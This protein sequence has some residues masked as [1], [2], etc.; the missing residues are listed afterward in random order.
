MSPAWY[1]AFQ[2]S[3]CRIMPKSIYTFR[4][5]GQTPSR[6]FPMRKQ[7]AAPHPHSAI[8]QHVIHAS[9]VKIL[10]TREQRRDPCLSCLRAVWRVACSQATYG[11]NSRD[12]Q[13]SPSLSP[14]AEVPDL[15]VLGFQ[16]GVKCVNTHVFAA[17]HQLPCSR[18]RATGLSIR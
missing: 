6:H 15:L 9:Q 1:R 13:S 8:Y 12:T 4:G 17:A 11:R 3:E 16:H 14:T 5:G 2:G 10:L 18:S 7:R